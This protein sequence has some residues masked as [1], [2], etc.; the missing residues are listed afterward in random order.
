MRKVQSLSLCGNQ[1]QKASKACKS[2]ICRLF[3][4]QCYAKRFKNSQYVGEQFGEQLEAKKN[5][6]QY[7][8]NVLFMN[9]FTA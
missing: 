6:H 4:F 2:T 1:Y 5:A 3:F 7:A 9:M 8:P